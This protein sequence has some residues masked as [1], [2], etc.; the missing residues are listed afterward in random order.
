M[1]KGLRVLKQGFSRIIRVIRRAG[2]DKK[3]GAE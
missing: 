3:V 1:R 2:I